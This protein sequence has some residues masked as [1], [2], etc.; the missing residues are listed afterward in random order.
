MS[1]NPRLSRASRSSEAGGITIL[2]ALVLI[3]VMGAAA[4][5]LSRSSIRELAITGTLVH[6]T[7]ADK[8]ADAGLDWFITWSHP[9]NVLANEGGGSAQGTV[10][11]T[12]V[13]LKRTD[14]SAYS[15]PTGVTVDAVNRPWDRAALV[16]SD[17]AS[18]A[19]NDMVFDITD[20]ARV[21]QHSGT[22][23]AIVQ[24]FDLELRFLGERGG[25]G[26]GDPSGGTD[27]KAKGSM[28][29]LWQVTSRGSANIPSAGIAF[30]QQRE[31]LGIQSRSQD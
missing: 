27:P 25:G 10:A 13:Y 11:Q 17:V 22:G 24:K 4:L 28:D 15:Y 18:A 14:W 12:I 8:A 3:T 7:K 30:A 5:G 9:D 31:A 1:L 2:V 29:L 21:K 19:T 20:A 6:G 16:T 26:A 23:N